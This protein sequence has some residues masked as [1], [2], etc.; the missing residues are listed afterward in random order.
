MKLTKKFTLIELLVVIAII[1]IL[2]AMLLPALNKA[3]DKAKA[4]K[5][6]NQ[7]KQLGLTI[8]FYVDDNDD[9]LP[10]TQNPFWVVTDPLYDTW[11]LQYLPSKKLAKTIVEC[12]ALQK[13]LVYGYGN[14][15][16]SHFWFKMKTWNKPRRKISECHRP[17]A[18]LFAADVNTISTNAVSAERYVLSHA[19]S[20]GKFPETG[21]NIDYR[22]S[23]YVNCLWGDGHA[24]QTNQVFLNDSSQVYWRGK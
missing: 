3:R 23:G 4:I 2:A 11:L 7:L 19:M 12:P 16:L 14:Y 1:A 9:W 13:G 8:A 6:T 24:S 10:S 22:H 17:T 20:G 15:G 21:K 18:T 5:C